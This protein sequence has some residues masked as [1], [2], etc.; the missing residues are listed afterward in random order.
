MAGS[1]QRL[2]YSTS[3]LV[4]TVAEVDG[5]QIVFYDDVMRENMKSL[6]VSIPVANQ[7]VFG[8]KV[9]YQEG[10]NQPLFIE[11]FKRFYCQGL[12]RTSYQWEIIS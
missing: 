12:P 9:Y 1:I 4:K 2:I 7:A 8:K 3:D 11:A 6:G 5:E 10:T